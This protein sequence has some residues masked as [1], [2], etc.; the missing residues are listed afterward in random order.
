MIG[1]G[2]MVLINLRV[3]RGVPDEPLGYETELNWTT[4]NQASPFL[5]HWWNERAML[6][7]GPLGEAWTAK[8]QAVVKDTKAK[9]F[10]DSGMTICATV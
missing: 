9:E 6:H 1:Y 5:W 10:D 7:V 4:L 2:D 8:P 3:G